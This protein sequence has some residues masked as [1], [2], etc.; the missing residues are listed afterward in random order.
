MMDKAPHDPRADFSLERLLP[1]LKERFGDSSDDWPAFRERL[2]AH[3]ADAFARL[4]GLYGH[5]YDF[6]W[7]LEQILC[8]AADAWR[9]RPAALRAID[10][11]HAA[12]P[13][14]FESN[15]QIGAV[16][17][18]D[19]FAGTLAGIREAVPYLVELGVT[20]LH[21]MPL[22]RSPPGEND[23]GYAVSDY[24]Q[25]NP[26]LG[27]MGELEQLAGELRR[28]GIALVVDFVFNH[29]ADDHPWALAA[30]TGD[31]HYQAYYWMFADKAETRQ[32]QPSLRAI[33]P[34]RG[35]DHFTWVDPPG[36]WVWTTFNRYQ[37]DLNFSN[38]VLFRRMLEELLFLANRGVQVLR[39]DAVPFIWKRAGTPCENLP[40]AHW[41]IQAF[42]ALVRIAAPSLLFKSEAIVHPNDVAAYIGP[43]EA[44]LSYNPTLMVELWNALATRETD[45]LRLY[46][47]QRFHT[48]PGTAWINYLRSHDDIGW[49]FADEDAWALG[50]NPGDHR[51]FLNDFYTGRF[52]GSFARGLPF[53]ENAETGDCRISGTQSSLIG[54]EKALLDGNDHELDLAIRRMLLVNAVI[55]T[56]GGIPLIYL[57]DEI[58]Q[59]N[60]YGFADDPPRAA[61][62]RWAHRP[63]FDWGRLGQIRSKRRGPKPWRRIHDGIKALI[64][65][66]KSQP[67]LAGQSLTTFPTGSRHL[68][69]Y[70]RQ[71]GKDRLLL[72]FN[73]SEHRLAFAG[74][75]LRLHGSAYRFRDLIG[76]TELAAEGDV[77]MA[78][79][80]ALCLMPLADD[81]IAP[82]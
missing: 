71:H 59:L 47:D 21:L 28:H 65:L 7:H 3:F 16:C 72:A 29:T 45:M 81:R 62:N 2:H 68:L 64:A 41:V 54:I 30:K 42:N 66:R 75:E 34:D 24:R 5:H 49:G 31:P 80:Q 23:G 25:V 14:W 8:A 61:D 46:F 39:L 82:Q 50:I 10:D 22:F 6:F 4:L 58:G 35:S 60:D 63:E 79:Y 56:A 36:K 33:F 55:M 73:L 11:E 78:P 74:A 13:N 77:A 57:G 48:E 53:Q 67:A 20:Y 27:T 43:G 44:Q 37:W 69:G 51:R 40:E 32:F 52:P 12:A 19:R 17:Y 70:V 15:A 18:V 26:A 38:P 1:R 9:D 76:G